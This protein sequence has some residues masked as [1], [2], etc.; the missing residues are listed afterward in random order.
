MRAQDIKELPTSSEAALAKACSQD[1]AAFLQTEQAIQ[2]L[3]L[4]DSDGMTHAMQMPVSA[5][6]LLVDLLSE[7]GEGNTVKLVPIHAELTTQ[8][9]ADM[10]NVSRPTLVKMLDEGDIPFHKTGNR[11]K[12]KFADVKLFQEQLE[13]KRLAALEE[14]SNIDQELNLG[15]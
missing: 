1:L 7:L 3:L 13:T 4:T 14:L 6:R 9:A 15:Y 11:R 10:L 5:L 8:E 12:V 2:E